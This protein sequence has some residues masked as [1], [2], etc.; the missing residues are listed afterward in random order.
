MTP[1]PGDA[2]SP[3]PEDAAAL[4]EAVDDAA[5]KESQEAVVESA[6][7]EPP[8]ADAFAFFTLEGEQF[9]GEGLP[10]GSAREVGFFRDVILE[11]ARAAWLDANPDRTYVPRGFERGFDLRL[12]VIRPGS[13][14]IGMRLPR[15]A[16]RDEAE[17]SDWQSAYGTGLDSLTDAVTTVAETGGLPPRFPV[18]AVAPFKRLGSTLNEDGRLVFGS[19]TNAVRRAQIDRSVR[20]LLQEIDEVVPP[21]QPTEASLTGVITEFDGDAQSFQIRTDDKLLHTCSIEHGNVRI[22]QEIHRYVAHDGITAPDVTVTGETTQPDAARV[23]LFNVRDLQIVRSLAEKAVVARLQTI[24]ALEPGWNGP[25]SF[26][27]AEDVRQR[28]E[29][30]APTI[31]TLGIPVKIVP[32]DDG[33]I[34][35]EWRRGAV[36]CTAAIE[37][38]EQMYLLADDT[39]TDQ[40]TEHEGDYDEPRLIG[41][42]TTGSMG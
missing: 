23:Q 19:P 15:A 28:V 42:L 14:R 40:Q 32:N 37:A 3:G 27:P 1:D 6:A 13:A 5:T 10:V 38:D 8:L 9:E 4:V 36:E 21:E 22:A 18:R 20:T 12:V 39:E 35:L 7:D 25:G 30:L 17:W 2:S 34:V 31:V 41:F 26:V 16:N 33:A 24:A 11:L 29:H